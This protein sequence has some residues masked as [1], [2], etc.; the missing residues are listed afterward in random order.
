MT[1]EKCDK[2]G[3]CVLNLRRLTFVSWLCAEPSG[4]MGTGLS[5]AAQAFHDQPAGSP[6]LIGRVW[7]TVSN[8]FGCSLAQREVSEHCKIGWFAISHGSHEKNVT[9]YD[10]GPVLQ[11]Q[12]VTSE[13]LP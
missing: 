4:F 6:N 10:N 3:K 2:G 8:Y 1:A 7:V 13:C 5:T 9:R 11:P 12:P